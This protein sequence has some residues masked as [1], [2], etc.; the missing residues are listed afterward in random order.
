MSYLVENRAESVQACES[1]AD[2]KAGPRFYTRPNQLCGFLPCPIYRSFRLRNS[3]ATS[4]TAK[5]ATLE[6]LVVTTKEVWSPVS[7]SK[8]ALL[9]SFRKGRC[10]CRPVCV[11]GGKPRLRGNVLQRSSPSQRLD[12][13][14]VMVVAAPTQ[15]K[16]YQPAEA[17]RLQ[18]IP[19]NGSTPMEVIQA[20]TSDG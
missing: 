14:V 9:L 19:D 4:D 10:R 6:R 20:L 11:C 8:A 18:L 13:S 7:S 16:S 2:S 5:K 17:K 3:S 12:F 1:W 15:I